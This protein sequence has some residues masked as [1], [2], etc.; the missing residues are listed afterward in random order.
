MG[1]EAIARDMTERRRLEDQLRQAGK[2]EAIGR[3]AGGIAHDFNNLLM[4]VT[5]YSELMLRAAR[6]AT[7]RCGRPR[8]RSLKAGDARRGADASA[9]GLQPEAG[10]DPVGARSERRGRRSRADAPPRHR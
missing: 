2:M 3:L 6:R 9:A 4:T 10:A 7:I 1:L 8:R 5:G